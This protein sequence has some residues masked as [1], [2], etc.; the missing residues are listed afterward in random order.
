MRVIKI[1]ENSGIPIYVIGT[2]NLFLKLYDNQLDPGRGINING[3]P[4]DR[5]TLLQAQNT[6][7]TFANSTGGQYFPITFPGEIPSVLQNI[8]ALVRNQYSLGYTPSNTRKE[9]KRRKIVVKVN[10]GDKIDPKLI[11]VQHRQ[12]YT[13][14]KETTK[15]T[16]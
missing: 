15:E 9:G 13:E 7:K 5:M 2:G 4:F 6:L 3:I 10:L 11:V 1:V 14:A 16:K 8:S 12:T